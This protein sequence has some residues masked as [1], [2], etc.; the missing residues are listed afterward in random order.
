[1]VRMAFEAQ[2]EDTAQPKRQ[3][4]VPVRI[5]WHNRPD[6]D[7]TEADIEDALQA[8]GRYGE[9]RAAGARDLDNA[10]ID[11]NA[12][13]QRRALDRAKYI[14]RVLGERKGQPKKHIDALQDG[15]YGMSHWEEAK[16]TLARAHENIAA[17]KLPGALV[18]TPALAS[19][20]DYAEKLLAKVEADLEKRG[21]LERK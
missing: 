14:E 8:A 17:S 20:L 12:Q 15:E 1:M 13:S 6:V 9:A 3:E 11:A 10:A 19:G 21:L 18:S 5:G 2:G 7:L 4:L 16:Q